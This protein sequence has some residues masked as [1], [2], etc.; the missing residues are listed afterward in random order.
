MLSMKSFI[1]EYDRMKGCS[2]DQELENWLVSQCENALKEFPEEQRIVSSMYNELGSFYRHHG[3]FEKGEEAFLKATT[4]WG[5]LEKDIDYA[6]IINNQAGNYRLMGKYNEAV[7]L[8]QE[9]IELYQKY[10]E[11]PK[12][13]ASSAYNNLALVYLD[14]GRF[15]EAA[16]ML[17]LSYEVLADTPDCYYEKATAYANMAIAYY[18]NGDM[19]TAAEKLQIAEELY[20]SGG[21]EDSPEFQSFLKLK[22]F[23][24]KK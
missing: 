3:M 23:L 22:E 18:K 24:V 10:P 5:P 7:S 11:T 15:Q 19:E 2:S 17:Q 4:I 12:A 14:T 9:A 16:D 6:T 20:R 8:F 21:L 13:L 1:S